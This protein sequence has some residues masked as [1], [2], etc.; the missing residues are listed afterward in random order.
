[1]SK[2]ITLC[3][4]VK[5]E[6]RVIERCLSSVLP[7]IDRWLIVDTGSTDGTQEKIKT[8]F[9]KMNIPGKL[10]ESPWVDFATN[11]S[12]ALK[13]ARE[14]TGEEASDYS[15]MIDADE[16]LV[17]EPGFEPA[18][19]KSE[20]TADL[21]NVFSVFG[22]TKYHRPQL[23]SHKKEFYYRC[24][25]HEYVDSHNGIE[26][27]DFA[28]GFVNTPIQD[29]AR[30]ADPEKY[31]KDA[32]LLES[33]LAGDR[34]P[35][36]ERDV[37]R[38]HFYLAQSYRDSHQWSKALKQYLKRV[39]LG[40]WNEE[41][42]YSYFQAGKIMELMMN[43]KEA[44]GPDDHNYTIDDIIRTYF[45]GFMIAPW[46][47]ESLHAAAVLCRLHARHGQAYELAKAA[48]KV[49]YPEG[50]LFV[51]QPAYDWLILDECAIAS[52]WTERFK[53][54]RS[55]GLQILKDG[56]YPPDQKARLESNL[57]FATKALINET[58]DR[59]NAEFVQATGLIPM[60][61]EAANGPAT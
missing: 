2:K 3:M 9:G 46:R 38:Y 22:G 1:M 57:D 60:P 49:K 12:Q 40:G 25:L 20:L 52:F 61:P 17:F 39:S 8:F 19:F 13:I 15:L 56:K 31:K 37:N 54:A 48:L 27:R 47:A 18:K 36:D 16:I 43:S 10:V 44:R 7:L 41:V 14:L 55:Y 11:R 53:E 21:Y 4:I 6:A 26:T 29:G 32:E 28:K 50:A 51:F 58:R 30:S 34:G 59:L 45:Q 42:F 33:V 23:T 5:N 35:V 24:V